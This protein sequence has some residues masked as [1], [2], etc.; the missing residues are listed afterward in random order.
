MNALPAHPAAPPPGE[1]AGAR[2]LDGYFFEDYRVGRAFVHATPRTLTPG[3]AALYHALT[4][5]RQIAH[6]SLP[7]ARALGHRDMPLDDLLVFH[8]AF[9]KTVAD[10]SYNAVANL[11]YADVRFLHPVYPGDTLRA[12]SQV[13]GVKENSDGRNGIVYVRSNA[14]NQDER[15]VLTWVRWVMVAKRDPAAPAPPKSIPEL[16]ALVASTA[17]AVPDFLKPRALDPVET[18]GTRRFEDYAAGQVIDHPGGMTLDESDHTLAAKLY[19]N[20]A[21]VHFDARHMAAT[22]FGRRLVYGGH[23]ISVCRALAYD[24]L[25]NVI[26][27]AAINAGTH[28]NATYAGDT[29]YAKSIVLDG[30]PLSADLG[31]LRLRMLGLK[32]AEPGSVAAPLGAPPASVVLDLDYTVLMPRR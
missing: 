17:L 16:P 25:E 23:V 20:T 24:G 11:G 28:V 6:C 15:N 18:G 32:D 2:P 19:Q 4:G 9:G 29:L 3:D 8:M 27:I 30:W 1:G 5:A 14:F 31:A 10:I 13:I 26:S 12:E 21:R 22:P 7:A